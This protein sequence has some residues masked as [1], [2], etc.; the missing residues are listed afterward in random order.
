MNVVNG[1]QESFFVGNYQERWKW[2]QN[3]EMLEGQQG[4]RWRRCYKL[5]KKSLDLDGE[6]VGEDNE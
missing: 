5:L 3:E 2:I 1:F 4:N 6:K